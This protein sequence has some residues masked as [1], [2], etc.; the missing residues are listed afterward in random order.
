[1][2]RFH[3]DKDRPIIPRPRI[4]EV[5]RVEQP[6]PSKTVVSTKKSETL[7]VDAV[8]YPIVC[9]KGYVSI[10]RNWLE[11]RYSHDLYHKLVT[12]IPW[13]QSEILMYGK[14]VTQPRLLY[15]MGFEGKHRYS[16]SS[17]KL[18]PFTPEIEEIM[19]RITSETKIP[20]NSCLLNFYPDGQSYISYHSDAELSSV[21]HHTV[22]TVSLGGSRDF[23]FK[24]KSL[25]NKETI[26]LELN[27]GDLTSMVGI[28]IQNN[29][30]HSIP[31]RASAD[32]RISL[33]YRW[34]DQ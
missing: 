11:T 22:A 31:K 34:L 15:G 14:I 6:Q 26:Q 32:G 12:T 17:I 23:Y 25:E 13:C 10:Q 24:S 3:V 1:M 33:T 28:A 21:N 19:N 29:W 4:C 18:E 20:F 5:S 2:L 30:T 27:S 7:I 8:E 9:D 16:G